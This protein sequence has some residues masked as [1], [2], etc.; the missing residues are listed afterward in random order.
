MKRFIKLMLAA[1]CIFPVVLMGCGNSSV[2]TQDKKSSVVDEVSEKSE[3][4][5]KNLPIAIIEVE[6][7]GYW[8]NYIQ[9]LHLIQ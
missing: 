3:E 1:I 5:T 2:D 6:N 9:K 8:Q 7:Y 4:E